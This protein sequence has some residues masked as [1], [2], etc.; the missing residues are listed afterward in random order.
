M[1]QEQNKTMTNY[2]GH[3]TTKSIE[4]PKPKWEHEHA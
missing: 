2:N 1:K 3:K 4:F